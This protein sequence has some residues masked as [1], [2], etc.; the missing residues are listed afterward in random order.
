METGHTVEQFHLNWNQCG[1]RMQESTE[2]AYTNRKNED[3]W[4]D[5]EVEGETVFTTSE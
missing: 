3:M 1:N 5:A 4:K 2:S